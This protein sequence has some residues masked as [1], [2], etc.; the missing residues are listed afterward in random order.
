VT[1]DEAGHAARYGP[2]LVFFVK[3]SAFL[4][5][6][7]LRVTGQQSATFAIV[8]ESA[9]TVHLFL[10]NFAVDNT[11][12][13]DGGGSRHQLSLKPREERTV[14]LPLEP[15]RTSIVVR[16]TSASGVKPSELEPGNL[17]QR[18][19]GCWVETR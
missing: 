3:G 11:V 14:D 9:P 16:I 18:V 13:V 5:P 10:R 15:G 6:G 19:L 17:D 7:G 4:E 8:P 2:A 12:T 1:S